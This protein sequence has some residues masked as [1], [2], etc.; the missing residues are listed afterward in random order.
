MSSSWQSIKSE[1]SNNFITLATAPALCVITVLLGTY[2]YGIE[3]DSRDNVI[4]T[5]VITIDSERSVQDDSQ[6]KIDE[7][8]ETEA[9]ALS[10]QFNVSLEEL[11]LAAS[12]QRFS[13]KIWLKQKRKTLSTVDYRALIKWIITV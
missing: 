12:K 13:L 10:E 3:K 2:L 5:H 4:E 11:N 6:L 9:A 1:L 7:L 8:Q